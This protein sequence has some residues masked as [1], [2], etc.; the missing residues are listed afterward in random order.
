MARNHF[1]CQSMTG[2]RL[3][4]QPTSEGYITALGCHWDERLYLSELMGPIFS[5]Y[6]DI[7]SSLTLALLE[8]SGWYK[9]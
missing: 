7:L 3:E 6:S 2:A 4:N 9:V 5:G 1:D 8:D